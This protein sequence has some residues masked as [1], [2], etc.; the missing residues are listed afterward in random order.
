[1]KKKLSMRDNQQDS[2]QVR[3]KELLELFA[4][5]MNE[6]IEDYDLRL[7]KEKRILR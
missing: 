5:D 2:F 3:V 6:C 7:Q 1:M 4:A